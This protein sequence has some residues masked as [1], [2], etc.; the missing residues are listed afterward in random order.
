MRVAIVAE[1]FPPRV[2]GVSRTVTALTAHLRRR[3]HRALIFVPGGGAREHDGFPVV[4]V[5]GAEA[6]SI[7]T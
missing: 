5:P 3:G 7:Q 1:S 6:G 4:G 2:D